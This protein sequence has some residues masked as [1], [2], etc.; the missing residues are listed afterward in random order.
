MAT[1]AV[2][3]AQV[4]ATEIVDVKL[5]VPR[6]H[7][8]HRGFFSE[9]Y[10]KADL[11]GLGVNLD[12]VQDNHSLSVE[13]GVVRGLHFQIPP[14]AQDKLVRVIRGSVFDVAVDIRR[15]S[16]TFGK[17]VARVISAAERNQFLVPAGFAH[18]FCTLEANTEVIYKVTNYYSPEHDRGL[19]WNDSDL[20]IPWP[21]TE[22]EAILSDKDRQ[23]PRFS[24]LPAY[25]R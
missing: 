23:L 5:I 6:I 16:P 25:F 24:E 12:F 18:G 1:S 2:Q 17:H 15:G 9:T 14:F 19:L 20:G 21:I 10:N 3:R 22:S 11:A 4:L 13:R 8:D 7:R